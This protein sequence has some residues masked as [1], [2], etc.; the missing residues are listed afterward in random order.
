MSDQWYYG[1]NGQQRGPIS[2]AALRDRIASGLTRG[3]ELVWRDGL[4]AWTPAQAVP[5][6]ADAVPAVAPPT[7]A[8]AGYAPA[9][10]A[11]TA[12]GYGSP[13][14]GYYAMVPGGVEYVGFWYR[15]LAAIIDGVVTGIGGAI[16][17]A[18]VG[19]ILGVTIGTDN[20]AMLIIQ[21]VSQLLGFIINW[22]YSATMESSSQQ[23]TLG[24]MAIGVRVTDLAGNRLSFG[25]AT[26]R[27]FG[28][29]LSSLI[30]GIGY[31]MVGWTEK[32][33]GLH[34]I[35][36]GTLVVKGRPSEVIGGPR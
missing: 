3:D 1:E 28:K 29:L 22:I 30:I 11:P 10:Y 32:K 9:C 20:K 34:D 4:A 21:I 35:V 31:L 27:F 24:K 13:A 33:Q 12:P 23:A 14:L 7:A 5:E 18:V 25:R 15:V 6:V 26:G 8:P 16:V 17:G 19:A 36:A 2:L